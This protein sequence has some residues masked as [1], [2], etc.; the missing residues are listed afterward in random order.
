[1]E[2]CGLIKNLLNENTTEE[3][4]YTRSGV[5]LLAR[6]MFSVVRPR[7]VY[8][9]QANKSPQKYLSFYTCRD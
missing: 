6:Y 4:F 2:I 8:M 1:M 3:I 9:Y 5:T 7:Y